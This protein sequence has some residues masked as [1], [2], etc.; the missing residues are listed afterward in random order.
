[1][2]STR[3]SSAAAFASTY[4]AVREP[5]QGTYSIVAFDPETGATGVAVQSHWFSVGTLVTWAEAGVGAVATQA[6]V[7]VSYGPEGIA[8]LRAGEMAPEALAALTA[9]DEFAAV[10]QVA[11][12]DARGNV[13][14]HTGAE[15]MRFAGQTVG[16][17]HSC[18]AN[19]MAGPAV[20]P[21]MS[22]AFEATGGGLTERL[23]A[24]LDAGEAAGG[25]IR[26]RQSAAILVVPGSGK[27]WETIV[28]LRVEDHPEPLVE[29]R[30][31]V[32]MHDAYVVA[33]EG[34]ELAGENRHDE[35]AAKYLEAYER[36]PDAI[37]LEFWAGLAL[38]RR[39][40]TDAGLAHLRATI[41]ANAG[42]RE[43]LDLLE[44]HTSPI[45]AEA[46]RLL[47]A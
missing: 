19:M 18:Q 2:E 9:A 12:V 45:A 1:M 46:R 3:H 41:A 37:E 14:A 27:P 40:E 11:I 7:D 28:E 20:W 29:L 10:R 5:R 23:L 32:A 21:A 6:N 22:A 16:A 39:G 25:D 35:A 36:A 34:D 17:H 24:A 38:I 42:W 30:R 47:D 44:P 13:A 15:C 33:G 8:R 31:L 4:P 26:G 43:L